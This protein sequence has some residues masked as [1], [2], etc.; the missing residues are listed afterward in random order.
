MNRV[1]LSIL[2]LTAFCSCMQKEY[3][4]PESEQHGK[5]SSDGLICTV[6]AEVK[7]SLN[8][9]LNVVWKMGDA[10]RV[11][12]ATGSSSIYSTADDNVSEAVF[13]PSEASV[14]DP[15]YA[16]YP[17][18]A[19][20]EVS[21]AGVMV[22][23][24]VLSEQ[25][26][27]SA[28][29]EGLDMSQIPMFGRFSDD[30]MNFSNLCGGIKLQLWDY[31]ANH[32]ILKNLKLKARGICS[33]TCVSVA[34]GSF[35]LADEDGEIVVDFGPEGYDLTQSAYDAPAKFLFFLPA[36]EYNSLEFELTTS[37][38]RVLSLASSKTVTV[39][40][41]VVSTLAV[42][43]LTFYYGNANSVQVI[44]GATATIDASAYYT[45]RPDYSYEN[46]QVKTSLGENWFPS[47]ASVCVVWEQAEGVSALTDG[48][49]LSSVSLSGN[50]ITA[51]SN[52]NR[53]NALVAIRDGNNN[54]LWSWHIWVS[55][56]N[57]VAYSYDGY[58][59]FIMHDRHLGAVSVSPKDFDAFGMF[60]QWGRKDPFPRPLEAGRT[61]GSSG[62]GVELTPNEAYGAEKG[63]IAYTISH[64]STR[65][66]A[67]D[68]PKDWHVA[69]NNALWG[70]PEV[71]TDE[72][73]AISLKGGVKTVY[74][75]CPKG[76]KVPEPY[77]YSAIK[78]DPDNA[79]NKS[80]SDT[81]YGYLFDTGNSSDS[82]WPTN[83]YLE[84]GANNMAF[85]G[86]R[87]Y[88]WSSVG[89]GDN[90]WYFYY[91]NADIKVSYAVR[92][93]AKSV[94]CLK[95]E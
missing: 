58:D 84:N 91:N 79:V 15:S 92:A 59:Q 39:M 71:A 63:V 89:A 1:I 25:S 18:S 37:D 48:S 69:R 42:R 44:P 64:P 2:V 16:I 72:T 20:G 41:G 61:T 67:S 31:Q 90:V 36:G 88:V 70:N 6:G 7:T 32:T 75:P 4:V 22:D 56:V 3:Q 52:G 27:M 34:D 46:C 66:I 76:Y 60:Y 82:Y 68:N 74:D 57:D 17:S 50:T 83:G 49:V 43:P 86:Y 5:I 26:H 78:N 53:G 33:N 29:S 55:E 14:Q 24:S 45:F 30:V 38:G 73:T 40:A 23:F 13:S 62:A 93:K 80:E 47:E 9:G 11:Y 21:G 28:L 81:N 19:A 95:I 12:S 8:A 10:I 85:N 87:G 77:Y 35:E 51:V 65:I 94:R 54:I